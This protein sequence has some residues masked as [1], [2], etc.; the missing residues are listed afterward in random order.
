[1]AVYNWNSIAEVF[2]MQAVKFGGSPCISFKRGSSY[3]DISWEDLHT[4]VRNTGYFLL[5]KGVRKGEKVAIYAQNC[6]EWVVADMAA[7]SVGAV[8]VPVYATNSPEEARYILDNSDSR[9]CFAGTVHHLDNVLKV[10][11]RLGKLREIILFDGMSDRNEVQSLSD[12]VA[13]GIIKPCMK[14]GLTQSSRRI[15]PL[16]SIPRE[17]PV[18]PVVLY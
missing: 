12:A 15:L 14:K 16:L 6:L 9:I 8:T 13:E 18:T 5:S 11:K 7:L 10:R 2:T 17:L 3:E 1:M 4:L